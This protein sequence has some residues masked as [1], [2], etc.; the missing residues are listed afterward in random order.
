MKRDTVTISKVSIG[1]D[2][3][4]SETAEDEPENANIIFL[5]EPRSSGASRHT[6]A[7]PDLYRSYSLKH[8]TSSLHESEVVLAAIVPASRW[9]SGSRVPK[10]LPLWTAQQ[11]GRWNDMPA[12]SRLLCRRCSSTVRGKAA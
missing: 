9:Q 5:S 6:V 11:A 12:V 8:A 10:R 3:V 4:A 7:E 2:Y 1:T